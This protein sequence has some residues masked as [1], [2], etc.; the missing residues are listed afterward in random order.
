MKKIQLFI[1]FLILGITAINSQDYSSF[2]N[3]GIDKKN[4]LEKQ[5]NLL[6][7]RITELNKKKDSL[8]I[9]ANNLSIKI[10]EQND[11]MNILNSLKSLIL[12]SNYSISNIVTDLNKFNVSF[13]TDAISEIDQ[14]ISNLKIDV[15]D[16]QQLYKKNEELIND[17]K[18][19]IETIKQMQDSLKN[20]SKKLFEFQL[21]S[22]ITFE[23]NKNEDGTILTPEINANYKK[24]KN[25]KGNLFYQ[26][27]LNSKI[28]LY[29]QK[30]DSSESL[31]N[32][33]KTGSDANLEVLFK[34][35][36]VKP[37]TSYGG[38]IGVSGK[39]N[40]LYERNF[41][42][43]TS[44]SVL[45]GSLLGII[46]IKF[47]PLVIAIQGEWNAY[48]GNKQIF[49]LDKLDNNTTLNLYI[50][51]RKGDVTGQIKYLL[52][53]KSNQNNS[54]VPEINLG[55]AYSIF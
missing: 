18:S 5:I 49:L 47:Y 31:I 24:A 42:N 43:K 32:I 9:N 26:F 29:G 20:N 7:N 10:N 55:I 2:S 35:G 44:P 3:I 4:V 14:L 15:E 51:I 17:T 34:F 40:L 52:F 36:F 13:S 27:E 6:K 25:I 1:L 46:G 38:I 16:N 37:D 12:D 48:T 19:K 11:T 22:Y 50:G 39:V 8:S 53:D 45:Y 23:I 33:I 21:A 54:K 28:K 41:V 30:E